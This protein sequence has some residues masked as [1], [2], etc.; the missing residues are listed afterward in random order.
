MRESIKRKIRSVLG[1][2][3]L[4]L[5]LLGMTAAAKDVVIVIDPGHGGSEAGAYR[6]WS[7]S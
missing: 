6:K 3:F 5:C 2:V 7:G 4:C 1:M